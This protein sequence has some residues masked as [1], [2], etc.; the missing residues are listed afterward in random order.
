MLIK[1]KF[2]KSS[3]NNRGI[4]LKDKSSYSVSSENSYSKAL[5]ELAMEANSLNQIEEQ[6]L[7]IT[8][9]ISINQDFNY[10]IK[11]PTIKIKDQHKAINEISKK[12]NFNQLFMKFLNFLTIKRRLFY[13]EKILND[14]LVI[15]SKM[16]GEISAELIAAKNLN[17]NEINKIKDELVK[18]FG[19]N[20]KLSY[21][22]DQGLIGGLI[23]KVGS[24]MIDS[25]IKNKLNQIENKLIE[26]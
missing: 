20:I 10:L 21:K 9:L 15:C 4:K 2:F 7:A 5:Y 18:T 11:D 12:F 25:S 17:E 23:V 13:L 8:K 22:Y 14:F 1:F 3:K 24:L 19:S 26:A 16:R 6:V